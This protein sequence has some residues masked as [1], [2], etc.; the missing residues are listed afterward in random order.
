MK[1]VAQKSK[2]S[3]GMI[4]M[5][6]VT[7]IYV[8]GI[9]VN[10]YLIIEAL[11]NTADIFIK[12]IPILFLVFFIQFFSNLYFKSDK[13]QK[14]LSDESG[15]MGWFYAIVSGILVSGPPYLL[16]PLLGNLKKKGMSD[17]LIAVFLYNRNV[18]IPFLP[19][20]V[21][22]FGLMRVVLLTIEHCHWE[23]SLEHLTYHKFN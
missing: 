6:I 2:L 18:K 7:G 17:A 20:M 14:Y 12:I 5:L 13:V 9:F 11:V 19:V 22:Y 21:L 8:G 10:K 3:K 4:F 23:I 1:S 16:F 15:K